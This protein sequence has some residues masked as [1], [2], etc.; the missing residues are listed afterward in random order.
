MVKILLVFKQEF[1]RSISFD[2]LDNC[3]LYGLKISVF[4][5]QEFSHFCFKMQPIKD[6]E[7]VQKKTKILLISRH[8]ILPLLTK[9]I[10]R[11]FHSTLLTRYKL[12]FS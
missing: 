4:S 3:F 5:N 9:K 11:F 6:V 1:V 12:T 8:E 10:L 7:L 2:N